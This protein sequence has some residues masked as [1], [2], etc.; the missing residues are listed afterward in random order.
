M[1]DFSALPD[2]PDNMPSHF[3]IQGLVKVSGARKERFWDKI[4][5]S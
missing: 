1:S 5:V 2:A 4:E 3:I